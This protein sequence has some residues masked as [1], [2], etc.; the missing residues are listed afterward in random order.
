[1]ALRAFFSF[2]EWTVTVDPAP[3]PPLSPASISESE[4]LDASST[5]A[6]VV[7]ASSGSSSILGFDMAERCAVNMLADG[8]DS[9]YNHVH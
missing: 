1:M 8:K 6:F 3:G 9:V 7:G 5:P 2:R 4:L